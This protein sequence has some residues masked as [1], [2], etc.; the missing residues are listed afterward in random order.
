[1]RFII[2]ILL[3][4][5][6]AAL[7]SCGKVYPD[8]PTM[9]RYEMV[10]DWHNLDTTMRSKRHYVQDLGVLSDKEVATFKEMWYVN[11]DQLTILEHLYYQKK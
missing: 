6:V 4:C 8:E 2:F 10:I 7:C 5:I 11:C 3:C 9:H 1:M